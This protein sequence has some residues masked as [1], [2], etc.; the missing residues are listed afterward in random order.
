MNTPPIDASAIERAAEVLRSGGLVALPTETVYGLAADADNEDAVRKLFA[1]KGRPADHPVIVH[2]DGTDAFDTWAKDVSDDARAL[3][4][5]FWPG[6]LTLV[7]TRAARV[8]DVVTGGQDTVGLRA[9]A[10]PWARAVLRVFGGALAAPSANSF[11]RVSPTT[12]Q[13]VIDDLGIKPRGRIDLVLDGGAC[14]VGIEST[15]VDVSGAKPTLLR[16]G[17][18]TREQLQRALGREVTDA[19]AAAPRASGRLE[20]HYSPHTPLS[21]VPADELAAQ[22]AKPSNERLAVL[23]P[24][25][26]LEKCRAD[27]AL[28]IAAP[29]RADDYARLLYSSLHRLDT[30]GAARLVVAAP[31]TGPQWDA[32]NDRL[33]RAQVGT[34]NT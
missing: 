34:A 32:V 16:P 33:R 29:D 27:V 19:G 28:A 7:L 5:A 4:R 3:G 24:L 10:H 20:K 15:I 30:S 6:P 31:P 14:P 25:S 12:A 17:S 9:P 11:G 18:I 1:A 22:L 21:V 23:A 26:L 2:V 8:R 13:H